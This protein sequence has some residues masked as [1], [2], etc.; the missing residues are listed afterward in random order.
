MASAAGSLFARVY[1]GHT[2]VDPYT[3][4]VSDTYQDLFSEGIFTGQGPLRRGRVHGGARGARARERAALA[5]PLRGPARAARARDRRRGG[6]RLSRRACSPTRAAST[7]GPAAT[8]RSSSGSS[9]WCRRATASSATRCPPISRWKILDN[10]RRTLVAPGHP[11][12]ARRRGWLVLPGRRLGVDRRDR[13]QPW[14]SRSIRHPAA[15]P[16]RAPRRSSRSGSS[17]ASA[18]GGRPDRRRAGAAAG[19]LPRL[20]RATRWC[21]P[22]SLTLVRLIV[23]PAPPARVGDGGGRGGARRGTRR[24]GAGSCS[25]WRRWRPAR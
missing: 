15:P 21:T 3:T 4:A 18:A 22:S 9:R 1:A 14:R 23:H 7:A 11:G 16:R 17:C 24:A 10:L 25:S 19:H 6:G 2:G 20:P 13:R 12:R 8:G 5:R